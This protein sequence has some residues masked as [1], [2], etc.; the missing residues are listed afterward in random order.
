MELTGLAQSPDQLRHGVPEGATIPKRVRFGWVMALLSTLGFSLAPPIAKA[1]I[2]GGMDPTTLLT[3]RL[4]LSTFLLGGA[5]LSNGAPLAID[6]R[7]LWVAGGAGLANGVGMI[8]FFWALT[9]IQASVGSM[10]FSL[11]PLVVLL[12]LAWRGERLT[13]RHALRL[14][15][16]LAGVYLL[17]GPGSL[18]A[19]G[20][21]WIG[22]GLVL[23]TIVTFALHLALIQWSLQGYDAHT[24]TFYVVAGMTLVS[25]AFWLFQGAEWHDPGWQGWLAIVALAVASTWL[26]RLALFAA[27]RSLGSG[28]IALLTP[29]ETFL[30]VL[31]SVLFLGEWLTTWQWLGGALIL[32]SALLAVR[33][34]GRTQRPFRWRAWSRL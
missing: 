25:F 13:R 27:V 24:V 7:G 9:R 17:I 11:S 6:R 29:L 21:D 2:T 18:S 33:R 30:T 22:V 15:L 31:W 16:G 32:L 20:T 1:A 19:G 10:I 26:A 12:M 23:V 4:I 8:T 14:A 3:M 28:Q 34:L 5:L